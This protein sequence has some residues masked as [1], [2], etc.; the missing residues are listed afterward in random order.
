VALVEH[1]GPVQDPDDPDAPVGRGGNPPTY[2][3]MRTPKFLYVEY[4]TGEKEYHDL[5]SDPDQLRNTYM[6]LPGD[7][8]AELQATLSK[9]Q[10]CRGSDQCQLGSTPTV[11]HISSGSDGYEAQAASHPAGWQRLVL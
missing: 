5:E 2:A 1:H 4:A 6:S 9:L 7:Q 11:Q 10:A 8:K 3:A